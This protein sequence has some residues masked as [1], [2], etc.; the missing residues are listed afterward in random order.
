MEVRDIGYALR[1][2][3]HN[4]LASSWLKMLLFSNSLCLLLKMSRWKGVCE[5]C[6][7]LPSFLDSQIWPATSTRKQVCAHVV[8]DVYVTV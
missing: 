4:C 1:D 2:V 6:F 7:S 5:W 3:L 8:S